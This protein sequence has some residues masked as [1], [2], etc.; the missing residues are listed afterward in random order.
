MNYD[1]L[2]FFHISSFF[3][4][5]KKQCSLE[6]ET[7]VLAQQKKSF[8]FKICKSIN[9]FC[10]LKHILRKVFLIENPFSSGSS[11]RFP[12]HLKNILVPAI[13]Q[14]D[15]CYDN[16]RDSIKPL[17]ICPEKLTRSREQMPWKNCWACARRARKLCF[18]GE[19]CLW[20]GVFWSRRWKIFLF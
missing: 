18:S 2:S 10:S 20:N 5:S 1:L 14:K 11:K 9:F 13:H 8:C 12:K 6:L 17:G 19:L 4:R 3:S 15:G 7:W 16:N